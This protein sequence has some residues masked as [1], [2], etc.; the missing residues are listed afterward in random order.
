MKI[1]KDLKI[2][3]QS[4]IYFLF[5][6]TFNSELI[7]LKEDYLPHLLSNNELLYNCFKIFASEKNN[8]Y[9]VNPENEIKDYIINYIKNKK[10][11]KIEIKNLNDFWINFLKLSKVFC[12]NEFTQKVLNF[13]LLDFSGVGSDAVPY[14]AVWTNVVEIDENFNVLNKEFALKRANERLLLYDDSLKLA[15]P[16]FE[17]WELE[18]EL[19]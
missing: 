16:K 13:N 15:I 17:S 1:P 10:L 14:F 9:K 5:K 11:Q 3:I 19:Y 18:Q 2:D 6:G 4:F 8:D 7:F 12:Y